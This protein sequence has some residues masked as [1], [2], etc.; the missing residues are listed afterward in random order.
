MSG[1]DVS[2]TVPA[3]TEPEETDTDTNGGEN[4]EGGEEAN[5]ETE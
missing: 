4:P 5:P 1:K 2:F 3:D